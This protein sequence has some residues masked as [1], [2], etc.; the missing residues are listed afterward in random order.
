[1]KLMEI[2]QQP[3]QFQNKEI[4]KCQKKGLIL[5]PNKFLLMKMII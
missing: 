5:V 1:M 3:H 4:F 2:K